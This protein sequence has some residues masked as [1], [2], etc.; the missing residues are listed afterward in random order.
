MIWAPTFHHSV[1]VRIERASDGA[2][3]RAR[4]L[5]GMGGYEA[6][7]IAI[8]R[9]LPMTEAQWGRFEQLLAESRFWQSSRWSQPFDGEIMDGD[10]VV[11][12][13]FEAGRSHRIREQMLDPA[14]VR[15]CGYLLELTG[16]VGVGTIWE[17]YHSGSSEDDPG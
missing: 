17:E 5:D 2:R 7:Q 4:V 16:I 9:S 10:V 6:G 12:E 11:F 3:L 14:P 15:L 1:C 8:D 13:G